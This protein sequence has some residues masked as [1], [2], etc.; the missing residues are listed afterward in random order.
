MDNDITET[1]FFIE[2]TE[3]GDRIGL[4]HEAEDSL[5]EIVY[6]EFPKVGQK[7]QEGELLAIVESTKAATELYAPVSG[8]VVRV[9]HA[10]E[11][12]EPLW[13]CIMKNG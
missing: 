9:N 6:I 3:E 12:G 4:T 1:N 11:K 2:S 5:G 10:W 8:E 7:I 13:I